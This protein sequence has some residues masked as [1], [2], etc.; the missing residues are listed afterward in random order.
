MTWRI[1][2]IAIDGR[3]IALAGAPPI[4]NDGDEVSATMMSTGELAS[5]GPGSSVAIFA[6]NVD[7]RPGYFYATWELTP[8]H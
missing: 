7:T 1:D 2:N 6:T 4:V 5:F 8:L 3:S